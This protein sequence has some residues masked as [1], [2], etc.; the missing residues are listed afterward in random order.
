MIKES[1]QEIYKLVYIYKYIS[2]ILGMVQKVID[3][4]CRNYKSLQTLLS[5]H[6][7]Q[8]A[9]VQKHVNSGWASAD[10][11]MLKERKLTLKLTLGYRVLMR[12]LG[13]I[14]DVSKLDH[15]R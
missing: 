3:A 1:E 8:P 14:D 2:E 10:G 7:W 12:G 6:L 11:R 4:S 13:D 15:H 5:M 9:D